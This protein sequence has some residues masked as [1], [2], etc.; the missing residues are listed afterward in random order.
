LPAESGLEKSRKIKTDCPEAVI[1]L[2]TTYDLPEYM[3][4]AQQHGID[5]LIPK[6][7]RPGEDIVALVRSVL[8]DSTKLSG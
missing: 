5:H 6:E 4:A 7:K 1:V 2:L 8:S 3:T